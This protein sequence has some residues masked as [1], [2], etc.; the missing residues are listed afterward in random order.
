MGLC[1][2]SAGRPGCTGASKLGVWQSGRY[3]AVLWDHLFLL[4][5]GETG[6][7]H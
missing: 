6:P 4:S 7:D 2:W 3:K 1:G 5:S